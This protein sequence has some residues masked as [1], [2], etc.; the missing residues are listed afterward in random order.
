MS[1]RKAFELNREEIKIACCKAFNTPVENFEN[2]NT[3]KAV[4]NARYAYWLI[5][6]KTQLM[7]LRE[8]GCSCGDRFVQTKPNVH[9]SIKRFKDRMRSNQ[10]IYDVFKTIGPELSAKTLIDSIAEEV[11]DGK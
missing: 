2:V 4:C 9:Q 1:D 5:L 10:L 8:I 11:L 3:S 7:T 6:R